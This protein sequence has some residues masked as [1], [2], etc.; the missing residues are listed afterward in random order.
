MSDETM[1]K[2]PDGTFAS[3]ESVSVKES[4]E[5]WSE[6]TLDDGTKIKL[7][8]NV[9]SVE[10][11]IKKYDDKG[12]PIYKLKTAPLIVIDYVPESLKTKV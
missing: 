6:V 3:L 7:K 10:R 12:N 4:N 5:K 11:A 1:E 8:L 9:I 2:L